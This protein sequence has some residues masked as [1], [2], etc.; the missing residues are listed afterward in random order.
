MAARRAIAETPADVAKPA[1]VVVLVGLGPTLEEGLGE[2]EELYWTGAC[3]PG[4][5]EQVAEATQN[6]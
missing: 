1:E 4:S 2:G 5:Y 6:N 3:L